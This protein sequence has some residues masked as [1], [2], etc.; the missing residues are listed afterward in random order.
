MIKTK[1]SYADKKYVSNLQHIITKPKM[2]IL[3]TIC[4]SNI[5]IKWF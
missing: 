4:L 3:Q 1:K 2:I 5:C